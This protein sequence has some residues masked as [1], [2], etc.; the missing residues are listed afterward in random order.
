ML[1]I[2]TNMASLNAQ[3]SLMHSTDSLQG[4]MSK[5]SSGMRITRASDDAAGLGV[6]QNLSAQIRSYNQAS[7]N[8][9][10][11]LSVVQTA[12]AALNETGNILTRMRELAMQSSSDGISNTERAYIQE[13]T[14]ALVEELN[15]IDA[16]TEFNGTTIFGAAAAMTFQVGIRESTN[17]F[18]TLDTTGMDV[19]AASIGDGTNDIADL[20]AGG[21]HDLATSAAQSRTA[22]AVIDGAI[23][24]VSSFRSELGAVANRLQSVQST[25]ASAAESVSAANSRIR[26]V[27]VAEET[28][29]MA[30]ANVLQQ[31]GVAVLAQANQQPQVA[32]KLLG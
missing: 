29:T 3:K 31:A 30:R 6:S 25:I 24:S 15:R 32:L 9:A 19:D 14:D 11:G 20:A 2:R 1:S 7:R 21:S 5:L 27:D 10:D 18:I 16:T 22:L 26:D 28:A 23:D 13:E 17:D 4:S 12:E 8:A